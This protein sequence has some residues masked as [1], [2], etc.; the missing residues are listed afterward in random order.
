LRKAV[1]G[2]AASGATLRGVAEAESTL[3]QQLGKVRNDHNIGK[4]KEYGNNE[5]I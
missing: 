5:K 1:D 3:A 2:L 4:E